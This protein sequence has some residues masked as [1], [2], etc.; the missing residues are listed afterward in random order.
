MAPTS[1][2]AKRLSKYGSHVFRDETVRTTIL[3]TYPADWFRNNLVKPEISWPENA[4]T[5]D[6]CRGTIMTNIKRDQT[7][8]TNLIQSFIKHMMTTEIK[9]VLTEDW[10]SFKVKIG[11]K[12]E[13]V[14]PMSL[15]R[16]KTFP[17]SCVVGATPAD[18]MYNLS[19][20]IYI[21]GVFRL[22]T[23]QHN[24]YSERVLPKIDSRLKA[25][26]FPYNLKATSGR[27]NKHWG[28]N[29]NFIMAMAALDMFFVKFPNNVYAEAKIG[30][31]I[32][33]FKD[34]VA[35]M[36]TEFI[37]DITSWTLP[38]I[39]QWCWVKK[40]G[41]DLDRTNKADQEF[42]KI[43]SYS[44]YMMPLGLCEKSAVSAT[45]NKNL[46][47]F[48]HVIGAS[49]GSERSKHAVMIGDD[50]TNLRANAVVLLY[51]MKFRNIFEMQ[52]TA[53]GEP[54]NFEKAEGDEFGEGEKDEPPRDLNPESW[55]VWMAD[56]NFHLPDYMYTNLVIFWKS[57][58]NTRLNKIG[59][60]LHDIAQSL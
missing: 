10:I 47:Y 42:D 37:R 16:F 34:C 46:H 26:S 2:I 20:L 50:T 45:A 15:L 18:P 55:F 13:T 39:A 1:P 59:Q 53:T 6:V 58:R 7:N 38:T 56:K 41:D 3:P 51:A 60:H 30:T 24:E 25:N 27:D 48:T 29:K 54:L 23:I 33:R 17:G 4:H 35:L 5:L 12:G 22:S 31:L 32:T 8:E 14:Y 40:L 49:L 9:E 36:E 11:D 43:D 19:L 28:G 57:F 44:P 21:T 52:Y